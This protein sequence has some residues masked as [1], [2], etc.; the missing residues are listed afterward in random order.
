MAV[1]C[2]ASMTPE[3]VRSMN[4]KIDELPAGGSR[5]PGAPVL[6]FPVLLFTD[7]MGFTDVFPFV[8]KTAG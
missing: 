8:E 6:V 7:I 2:V 1:A 4:Q 3:E 5:L